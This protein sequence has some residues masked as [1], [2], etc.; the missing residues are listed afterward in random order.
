MKN[1]HELQFEGKAGIRFRILENVSDCNAA[2]E[3]TSTTGGPAGA[4][5][6]EDPV[7]GR[8]P[9]PVDLGTD[10][11]TTATTIVSGW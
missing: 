5:S 11:A 9:D 3:S 8:N 1:T 2:D 4:T 10:N 6:T 7:Q